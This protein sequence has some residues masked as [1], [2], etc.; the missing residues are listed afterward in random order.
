MYQSIIITNSIQQ[1]CVTAGERFINIVLLKNI[2]FEH[3]VET[4]TLTVIELSTHSCDSTCFVQYIF[5]GLTLYI[6]FTYCHDVV[7][8][9]AKKG[10]KPNSSKIGLERLYSLKFIQNI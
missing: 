6:L 4:V 3:S 8:F 5:L 9:A 10:N 7:T 1:W 2:R